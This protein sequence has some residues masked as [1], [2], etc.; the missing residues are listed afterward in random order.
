[1]E[2]IVGI[3]GGVLA[4]LLGA[5]AIASAPAIARWTVRRAVVRL[6]EELQDRYSE[7]WL[8]VVE[9]VPGP[10]L[11]LW[12]ALGYVLATGS[13]VRLRVGKAVVVAQSDASSGSSGKLVGAK[14]GF[15]TAA[16]SGATA[17]A[18]LASGAVLSLVSSD[19]FAL[20]VRWLW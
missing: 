13:L 15:W 18:A 7:E 3:L 14:I 6:P 5:Q 1:M 20:L 19:F 4:A 12:T 10:L 16:L 17:G 8:R 11:K 2:F 9:D